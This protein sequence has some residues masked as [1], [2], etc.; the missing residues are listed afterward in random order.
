MQ[1][2]FIL[3]RYIWLSPRFAVFCLLDEFF[4]LWHFVLLINNVMCSRHYYKALI[5]YLQ[6]IRKVADNYMYLKSNL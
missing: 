2:L 4:P 1:R 6:E 5:L 3:L